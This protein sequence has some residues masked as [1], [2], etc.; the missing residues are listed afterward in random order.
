MYDQ[1]YNRMHSDAYTQG[2]FNNNNL[3]LPVTI[4]LDIDLSSPQ[5]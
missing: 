5:L 3:V 4:K 2:S 1:Q